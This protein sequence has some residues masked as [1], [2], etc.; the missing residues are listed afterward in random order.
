MW[1]C[2]QDFT[3]DLLQTRVKDQKSDARQGKSGIEDV[4]K[5]SSSPLSM[6]RIAK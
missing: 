5:L 3:E 6:H 1:R 4:A 2:Y